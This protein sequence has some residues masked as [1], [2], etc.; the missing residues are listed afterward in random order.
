MN[1]T[2][3]ASRGWIDRFAILRQAWP[4][5]AGLLL[6]AGSWK[7]ISLAATA[8][9]GMGSLVR[10]TLVT[11]V[12]FSGPGLFALR[13]FP[14]LD[15]SRLG[16]G[17][18]VVLISLGGN[19][20]AVWLLYMLG[21]YTP[22]ATWAVVA[23][24]AVLGVLGVHALRPSAAARAFH[25]WWIS[26]PVLDRAVFAVLA[27]DLTLVC[28]QTAGTHFWAWD[29]IVS[30]D[31]WG[32][33]MAERTG[34]GRYVM[35]GYPQMLPALYSVYYKLAGSWLQGLPD[36]QLLL[37]GLNAAFAVLLL[38][39]LIRL[40]AVLR[41]RGSL[42]AVVLFGNQHLRGWLDLGYA[43][44]P[45]TA[46][47]IGGLALLLGRAQAVAETTGC[48]RRA[49]GWLL[50]LPVFLM[51]FSKAQGVLY[52]LLGFG[53][54]LWLVPAGSR[55]SMAAAL[56]P[57]LAAGFVLVAPFYA[58][59]LFYS[60]HSDQADPDPR[61]HTM[62]VE[63]AKP[64]LIEVSRVRALAQGEDLAEAY[65]QM[66]ALNRIDGSLYGAVFWGGV[67][68]AAF[69]R[70]L[71]PIAAM[72]AAGYLLWFFTVS[73]DWRN[74]FV[75]LALFA[76]MIAGG[77]TALAD[78]WR[79][80]AWAGGVLMALAVLFFGTGWLWTVATA[81]P[82]W[83]P[84]VSAPPMWRTEL[85]GRFRIASPGFRVVRVFLQQSPLGRRAHRIYCAN[86]LYR[87]LGEKGVYTLKGNSFSDVR[88]GDLL[89]H[90]D[91]EP[92]PK[93]FVPVAKMQ[94]LVYDT[95]AMAAPGGEPVDFKF[96]SG[97]GVTV[98][99][100]AAGGF[101]LTGSGAAELFLNLP[102]NLAGQ[103]VVLFQ[104]DYEPADAAIEVSLSPDWDAASVLSTRMLF[105]TGQGQARGLVWL[106]KLP[107]GQSLP[108]PWP[109]RLEK[110]TAG[111]VRIRRVLV[112]SVPP[113]G[114]A[115]PSDG[116]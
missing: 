40:C 55:R 76:V 102:F 77:V 89:L 47:A 105:H 5:L 61:C 87:Y 83:R 53:A 46:V 29:S 88:P 64:K 74:A 15:A 1:S 18:W 7:W 22:A 33:D 11:A 116:G 32:C 26:Q 63:A 71:R 82:A 73:Y 39:G 54:A 31:K 90:S 58:H 108:A 13:R 60:R 86:I 75:P 62:I 17:L 113:A 28:L 101:T 112:E 93:D 69:I 111:S 103:A 12:L 37:H 34:L 66:P 56:G 92:F 94:S 72:A 110:N 36:E 107:A 80:P 2:P 65:R 41:V 21:L 20:L 42:A 98:T 84:V 9:H 114:S 25:D 16:R 106:D 35:G 85:E 115:A 38:A 14:D 100:D 59:Q 51:G 70:R 52:A 8:P 49:A 67:L 48:S 109:I 91:G 50:A 78:R 45:A 44:I 79:K 6:I 24:S 3:P 27:L 104:I 96:R 19:I 4:W 57:G 68:A 95:L 97:A 23:G 10:F 30:W 99:G 81:L 43:D